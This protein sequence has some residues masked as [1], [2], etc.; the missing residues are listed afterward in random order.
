MALQPASVQREASWAGWRIPLGPAARVYYRLA[1]ARY[2]GVYL[3]IAV[4]ACLLA[5]VAIRELDALVGG[6]HLP[7]E[8]SAGLRRL[9][10][11]PAQSGEVVLAWRRFALAAGPG[12]TDARFVLG[13]RLIVDTAFVVAYVS[14]ASILLLRA[15]FRS[16]MKRAVHAGV[17]TRALLGGANEDEAFAVAEHVSN[18]RSLIQNFVLDLAFLGVLVLGFVS[19]LENGLFWSVLRAYWDASPADP[20]GGWGPV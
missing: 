20:G 9:A 14:A 5:L 18:Q 13:L 15:P 16:E 11:N 2:W 19:W 12:F 10:T 8:P 17:R 1:N 3:S 6:M 7:G 4:A